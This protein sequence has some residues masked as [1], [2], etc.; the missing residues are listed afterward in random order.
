MKEK[1]KFFGEISFFTGAPRTASVISND[2]TVLII[3]DRERFIEILRQSP[4]DYVFSIIV[5]NT[6]F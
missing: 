6:K 1:G 4:K 5:S 2:V 3:L